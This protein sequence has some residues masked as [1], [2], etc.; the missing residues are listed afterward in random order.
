MESPRRFVSLLCRQSIWKDFL[1]LELN[2]LSGRLTT[3]SRDSLSQETPRLPSTGASGIISSRLHRA[4]PAEVGGLLAASWLQALN[5]LV[6]STLDIYWSKRSAVLA[7]NL[8]EEQVHPNGAD[9]D[10]QHSRLLVP[11]TLSGS[12]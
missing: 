3:D 11:P 6:A 7:Q 4:R 8:H 2:S 9:V 5:T 10:F 1:N 12:R